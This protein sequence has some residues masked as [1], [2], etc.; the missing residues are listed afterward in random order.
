MPGVFC[1]FRATKFWLSKFAWGRPQPPKGL[2]RASKWVALPVKL[3]GG[4]VLVTV[5]LTGLLETPLTAT[6]TETAPAIMSGTV[7]TIELLLQAVTTAGVTPKATVLEPC[8]A[9]NPDPA[10]VTEL[11]AFAM[12]GLMDATARPAAAVV[13]VA[14]L[15]GPDSPAL[16]TAVTR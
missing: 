3:C 16:F 15:D 9:P 10:M 7:A 4:G 8:E 1:T 6:V 13:A 12:A 5:K 11:P 14:W 2:P